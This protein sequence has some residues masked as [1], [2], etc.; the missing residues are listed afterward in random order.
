MS[1]GLRR[2]GV[3]LLSLTLASWIGGQVFAFQNGNHPTLGRPPGHVGKYA[4]YAPT[5]YPAWLWR[6]GWQRPA[7][8]QISGSVVVGVLVLGLLSVAPRKAKESTHVQWATPRQ[9]RRAK[10]LRRRGVVVGRLK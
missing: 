6:W 10:L 8:F 7:A 5:A 9:L 2:V 4:L 3:G 1:N